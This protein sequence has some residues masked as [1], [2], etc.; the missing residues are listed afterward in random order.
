MFQL[1]WVCSAPSE[2]EASA[3]KWNESTFSL[4]VTTVAD[5]SWQEFQHRPLTQPLI[6]SSLPAQWGRSE[7]HS[8]NQHRHHQ[9]SL[10]TLHKTPLE[11]VR[12]CGA[13]TTVVNYHFKPLWDK[14]VR[15]APIHINTSCDFQKTLHLLVHLS[16]PL[17]YFVLERLWLCNTWSAA[18]LLA[19]R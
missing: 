5:L 7:R 17:N 15:L 6:G 8:G 3:L 19:E 13:C 1:H 12:W 2:K 9:G 4:Q 14:S 11:D 10:F 16:P 18:V